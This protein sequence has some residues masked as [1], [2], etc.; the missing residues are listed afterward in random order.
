MEKDL[1]SHRI[2]SRLRHYRQQR[3]LSLDALADLTGVSKPMLGQIERGTSNPTVATLWKIASGLHV[4]FTSFISENPSLQI[5]REQDQDV[6]YEDNKLFEVFTTFAEQG[7]PLEM[8][9]IKLYP[10]CK[11]EADAHGPGVMESIT[12]YNGC[13]NIQIGDEQFYLEK[14]DALSFSADIHHIYENRT[15]EIC[16]LAMSILYQSGR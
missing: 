13:L 14:G 6:F 2:G 11:R 4:P 16:E 9:R 1:L 10:G 5:L 7:L 15:E 3:Q 12:V 8:Y